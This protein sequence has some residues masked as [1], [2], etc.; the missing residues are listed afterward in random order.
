MLI[1]VS[2]G[3]MGAI[4]GTLAAALG[5]GVADVATKYYLPQAGSSIIY[6]VTVAVMLWRPQGLLGR[7]LGH[8]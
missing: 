3:G 4:T 1:I 5:I 7:K 2:V 6:I 8:A